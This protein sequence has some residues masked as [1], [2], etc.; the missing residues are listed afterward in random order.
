MKYVAIAAAVLG[1]RPAH[2]N[3]AHHPGLLA[4]GLQNAPHR[5]L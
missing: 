3:H 1:L 5:T 2:K 4:D